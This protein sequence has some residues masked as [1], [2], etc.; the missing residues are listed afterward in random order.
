MVEV[1]VIRELYQA[2][3]GCC[4]DHGDPVAAVAAADLL[5]LYSC[6]RAAGFVKQSDSHGADEPDAVAQQV[7]AGRYE[8][9]GV[10]SIGGEQ[11]PDVPLA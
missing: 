2:A 4:V 5:L 6:S 8:G 11:G 7:F 1:V 9:D 10:R 3:R